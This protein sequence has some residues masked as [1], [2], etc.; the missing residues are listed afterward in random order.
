MIAPGDKPPG[1]GK[2]ARNEQVK[3]TG[4]WLNGAAITAVAIGCFAPIT[5]VITGTAPIRPPTLFALVACWLL[6]ALVLHV[7]ARIAVRGIEE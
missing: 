7:G 6:V 3:I 5:A 1:L 2:A 4:T